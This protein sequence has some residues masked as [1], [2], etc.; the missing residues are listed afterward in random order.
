MT[1][2][3]TKPAKIVWTYDDYRLIPDDGFRYEVIDGDLIVTPAPSTLHQAI[4]KRLQMALMLQIEQ[5]G[6]G[7]VFNAPID[8]IFTSTRTVQPD[9]LVVAT[10][11]RNIV[12]QRGIEGPPDL[13]V[14]IG[15]PTTESRD[16]GVKLKLYATEG[17]REYWIVDP[18]AH[19][20]EVLALG[21][22]GYVTHARHGP[23]QRVASLIFN[24]SIEVDPLFAPP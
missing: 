12:T 23:G 11:R 15:S 20:V 21:E 22:T 3:Q 14:E 5:P 19:V 4:S 10:P 18:E 2:P 7:V 13:I 9:L 1:L 6:H 24:L 8:V 17:V 16:R